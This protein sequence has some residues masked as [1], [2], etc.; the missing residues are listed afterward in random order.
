MHAQATTFK[1]ARR[2]LRGL[3]TALEKRVLLW[4]AARMPAWVGSDHLT[5]LGLLAMIG[6]GAAYWLGGHEAR[7][8]LAVNALLA[9]NWFGD[10]LDGTLA[11]FRNRCRPRYGFYVDHMVDMFGALFLLAGLA[12][13]GY[14]S[15]AVAAALLLTY[16]LLSINVYLAT[17]TL[18][19]F[20]ISFGGLG[21]TELR[22]LLMAGN[23]LVMQAPHFVVGGRPILWF[24]AAGALAALGMAGVLV[25]ATLKNTRALYELERI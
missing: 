21:G 7:W 3:T 12:L 23:V 19:V 6:A 14:M 10:S 17:Y 18:G 16:Y 13:S 20:K 22:L 11:R 1:D 9:V 24:D 25:V 4:L 2:D 5:A 8:L 15:V